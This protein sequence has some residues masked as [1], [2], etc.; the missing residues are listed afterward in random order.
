MAGGS[1][2]GEVLR[3]V[4]S[5]EA[6]LLAVA[7]AL[8]GAR[9]WDA[10]ARV[11]EEPRPVPRAIGSTTAELLRDALAKGVVRELMRR[12]GARLRFWERGPLP[13]PLHFSRASFALLTWLVE[14]PLAEPV[15][16]RSLSF[17]ELTPA[18]ELLLYLCCS[19]VV[20]TRCEVAVLAQ[21]PVRATA[22]C[23]LAFPDALAAA[24]DLPEQ[25]PFELGD[26]RA[27]W[28]EAL[29]PELA[30]RW[31]RL[32][33]RKGRVVAPLEL[34]R[35]GTA[36]ERVL[37]GFTAAA[38][39]A[40][41]RDLCVF[42]IEAAARLLQGTPSAESW[43]ESLDR[44]GPLG[45]RMEA[46]RAAGAFLRGLERLRRWDREH[47]AIRFFDDGYPAAQHLLR[48]WERLGEGGFAAT[49]RVLR[50]L[51]LGGGEDAAPAPLP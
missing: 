1:G 9:G 18:D 46:R 5:D 7:H 29:Q 24:A 43:V 2:Q 6:N 39:R 16:C 36:Q 42:W 40:G 21:P 27:L 30:Q 47:R 35:I 48:R 31:E 19:R 28:I 12:G 22:L 38:D 3:R 45:P 41:R 10:V 44:T 33:R 13:P 25:L 11:F 4:R 26:A 17:T 20:G 14:S 23:W 34:I 32:E 50:G 8:V 37:E 15:R 51:E 49:E